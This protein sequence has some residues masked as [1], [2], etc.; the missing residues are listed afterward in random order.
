M[1]V[2]HEHNKAPNLDRIVL[3]LDLF[4]FLN[5]ENDSNQVDLGTLSHI[6]Y[7]SNLG[8]VLR[9]VRNSSVVLSFCY[10]RVSFK[11]KAE[12]ILAWRESFVSLLNSSI[13]EVVDFTFLKSCIEQVCSFIKEVS[14]DYRP[15]L[16]NQFELQNCTT[17]FSLSFLVLLW[18]SCL[19][20]PVSREC[21]KR[22]YG[23]GGAVSEWKLFSW[24][25]IRLKMRLLVTSRMLLFR[26]E[27]LPIKILTWVLWLRLLQRSLK[28]WLIIISMWNPRI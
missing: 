13:H 16:V 14:L 9:L 11:E 24:L 6:L 12:I 10:V 5:L 20:S 17:T 21:V 19:Y 4:L 23:S 3:Q 7:F 1:T 18:Y 25:L 8:V 27:L 15:V 22:L 2:I 28:S 26:T